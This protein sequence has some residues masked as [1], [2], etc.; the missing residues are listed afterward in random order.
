MDRFHIYEE[1]GAG[2]K[3][4]V[5]KG[6]ERSTIKYVAIKRVD[7]TEMSRY[8]WG[9]KTFRYT[10]ALQNRTT[11]KCTTERK[12]WAQAIVLYHLAR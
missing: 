3:S 12:N 5:Y 9:G 2:E 8:V 1:I 11:T 7:K 10:R 6:R 4:Q